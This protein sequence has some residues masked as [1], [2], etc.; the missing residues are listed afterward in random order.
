MAKLGK[1]VA[2]DVDGQLFTFQR[3]GNQA[4]QMGWPNPSGPRQAWISFTAI[5][6]PT[7]PAPVVPSLTVQPLSAVPQ[8]AAPVPPVAAVPPIRF[9]QNGPWAWYRLVTGR[10]QRTADRIAV[11][12]SAGSGPQLPPHFTR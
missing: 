8:P 10:M 9:G 12:V 3:D 5:P 11:P 4:T 6:A 1:E 7:V 2:V